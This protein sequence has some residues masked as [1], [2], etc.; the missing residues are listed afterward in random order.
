MNESSSLPAWLIRTSTSNGRLPPGLMASSTWTS[1]SRLSRSRAS[2]TQRPVMA[3][4]RSRRRSTVVVHTPISLHLRYVLS[5]HRVSPL[6]CDLLKP[7]L[8]PCL[9]FT[10]CP[11]M[12]VFSYPFATIPHS[13]PSPYRYL[14]MLLCT[15]PCVCSY[16]RAAT[17]PHHLSLEEIIYYQYMVALKPS[18]VS[19]VPLA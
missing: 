19:T 18:C 9:P 7:P 15:G 8:C 17:P 12:I 14:S 2:S 13:H 6:S 3:S 11:K 16:V 4:P 10:M 1:S 5:A